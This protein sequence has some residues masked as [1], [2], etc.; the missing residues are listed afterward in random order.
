MRMNRPV[1]IKIVEKTIQGVIL[2]Y[3][4]FLILPLIQYALSPASSTTV[5]VVGTAQKDVD[6]YVW[7]AKSLKMKLIDHGIPDV[8]I[9][10]KGVKDFGELNG[11]INHNL[12]MGEQLLSDTGRV[13]MGSNAAWVAHL[14][15]VKDTGWRGKSYQDLSYGGGIS[16]KIVAQYEA[17]NKRK[18]DYS[19]PGIVLT[20]ENK[21]EVLIKGIDY[22]HGVEL[23]SGNDRIPYNGW[24]EM[25]ETKEKVMKTFELDVLE[26]GQRR[27][28]DLGLKPIVPAVVNRYSPLCETSYLTGDMSNLE[29][30]MPYFF[31]LSEWVIYHKSIYDKSN[32][33][34]VFWSSEYPD[35]KAG[36]LKKEIDLKTAKSA[37]IKVIKSPLFT[38]EGK[39][40]LKLQ[41][42]GSKKE[43]YMTGVNLGTALPGKFFTEMP[44]SYALYYDWF[45]KQSRMNINTV[46]IYTLL[47]PMF[48]KALA[49]FNVLNEKKLYLLQ[50]IWPEEHP[51]NKDYL[52]TAYN[53][54]YKKEIQ[55]TV[56][57]VHG[58]ISI[59]KRDYRASGVYAYDVSPYLIGYLVGRELE[60]EEVL[61]TN[62][63]HPNFAFSG[64]YLYSEPGASASEAWLAASCED[65]LKEAE[66]YSEKPLVA[67]V[68]WP[69]LD[70]LEHESGWT[71][72]GLKK[73]GTND[74]VTIDINKIGIFPN[75]GVGLFGAYH[76]YPNY[77]DFINNDP[78]YAQGK[79][80]QGQFRYMGYLQSFMATQ[81]KYPAIVAEYGLSDSMTTAH[82]SPDGL[83]HGGLNQWDQANG[84][85]RMNQAIQETGYAG[86]IIFQWMDEWAKKTWTTEPFMIPYNRHA[87][88]HNAMDPEQNY[89]V[90]AVTSKE[91][92]K[93]LFDYPKT[94]GVKAIQI[95]NDYEFITL[96]FDLEKPLSELGKIE[97]GISILEEGKAYV[98]EF[99]LGLSANQ[100][101]L[102]VQKSYNWTTG[103]FSPNEVTGAL[104]DM[105]IDTNNEAYL[106][107]GK[108]I[109]KVSVN[110]SDLKM[111]S[112]RSSVN[113]VEIQGNRVRVRLPYTML[114]ISDPSSLAV[115]Y[116]KR[117]FIPVGQD[118]LTIARTEGIVFDL[119]GYRIK[120]SWSPWD[121][122]DYVIQPKPAYDILAT[123]F[124]QLGN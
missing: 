64:K 122:V 124:K 71:K 14:F 40:I 114:G 118:Q 96:T 112:L 1:T 120:Y 29:I 42:D 95:Q 68:S 77:P 3:L 110:L 105:V 33:E 74:L 4:A 70:V 30:N 39:Q 83:N 89:G 86:A 56:Q 79:D 108:K 21:V 49:D 55:M 47:P 100:S 51:A 106:K 93:T 27:F 82:V 6:P 97:L 19:G 67:I 35:L 11:K 5:T 15:N 104:E 9:I 117:A 12:V 99:Q 85:I 81:K 18:W 46:R 111:G 73:S 62:T 57:A 45:E 121:D 63:L 54:A 7:V 94:M 119:S 32:N 107:S 88:W 13:S 24:F 43:F 123:Y 103:R 76:I 65:T 28:V 66:R 60:P 92:L 16:E 38:I 17:L 113:Q 44:E 87:L 22:K 72:D 34:K 2:L 53:E 115:L 101:R 31:S 58:D 69:P 102:Q 8:L 61:A 25:V 48:Y 37:D 23:V 41:N 90:M 50:E 26:N 36:L 116:D 20:S 109:G 59:P 80:H 78:T 52:G 75:S 84:I 91:P 10:K 98:P